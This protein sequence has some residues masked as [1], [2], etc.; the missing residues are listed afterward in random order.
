MDILHVD[1][2]NFFA[3]CEMIEHPEY[4][5]IPLAV[6]GNENDRHGIILAKN[7]PA[8]DRGIQTGMTLYQARKIC[9]GIK[10]VEPHFDLYIKY[11]RLVRGILLR[12]TDRVEPFSIDESWLDVTHSKIFGTPV[13]IADKIREDVKRETGLTVSVGVSFCKIFAK[14]GS[15]LKK[16]DATT[17]ISREN[18]R[19]VVWKLPA[20]DLMGVGGK[21][22]EK[23][24]K[25]AIYTIGDIARANK[26]FLSDIIGKAGLDLY[27]YANGEDKEEVALYDETYTPKSVG[28]STTFYKDLTNLTEIELGFTVLCENVVERM[29]KYSLAKAR[30]ICITVKDKDLK[31]YTKQKKLS[32]PCRDSITFT[33]E[34]MDLFE[35]NFRSIPFI[36][37]LG[38][39]VTDF[40]EGDFEYQMSFFDTKERKDID[41]VMM[42]IRDKFGHSSIVKANNLFDKKIADT[43]SDEDKSDKNK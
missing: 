6:G 8:K 2:N 22:A 20:G 29:I 10:L 43:F 5:D 32:P 41:S 34:C 38:V 39:S 21:T 17:V 13:E 37:L 19:E 36:R 35:K 24:K 14:L 28:N 42:K 7:Y 25:Y 9:P 18:F 16:P 11:S 31:V 3:S 30:T 1:L 23:L 40:V 15:D 33:N 12:Y 27:R 4:R 26:D